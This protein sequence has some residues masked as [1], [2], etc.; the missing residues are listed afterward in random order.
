MSRT[1][2]HCSSS[3]IDEDP[4]RGDATCMGCGMVL[5]ESRI[6]SDVQFQ[7]TGSGAHE[8][9]GQFVSQDKAGTGGNGQPKTESR[10]VTYFKG[11]KLIQ[12]IASQLRINQHCINTAYNFFKLCVNSNYTR[13]RVRAHVVVA[14]LYM[15]CRL[16]NTSHLLLDFSDVTQVN[17]FDL[18]RTLNFLSRSLKINLP[19][20]DPC[21]YV[22]RFAIMLDFGDKQRDVVSLATRIVQR[23]KRDWMATGRRPTGI[24][25]AAH[26]F[27]RHELSMSIEQFRI[28]ETVVRKRLDEFANTAS[29]NL[30]IDEFNVVDLEDCADPPAYQE[31]RLRR[32]RDS[33]RQEE[34]MQADQVT[35]E[36]ENI[37]EAIESALRDKMKR[38]SYGATLIGQSRDISVPEL[39]EAQVQIQSEI[40][41]EIYSVAENGNAHNEQSPFQE[42]VNY[43]PT[44][45]SLG[46]ARQD[47]PASSSVLNSQPTTSQYQQES[48]IDD[49]DELKF[50]DLDEDELDAYILSEQE[51]KMKTDLWMVRNGQH[52]EEMEKKRQAKLEEEEKERANPKKKR[53]VIHKQ[54]INAAN[55]NEAMLQVIQEKHLS[56]KINYD[57]LKELDSDKPFSLRSPERSTKLPSPVKMQTIAQPIDQKPPRAVSPIKKPV[58][59]PVQ[60]P[61]EATTATEFIKPAS[62]V[63]QP[64][65]QEVTPTIQPKLA[66]TAKTKTQSR[67]KHR[68]MPMAMRAK[69]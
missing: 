2:P 49:G 19:T 39:Q 9:I 3:E 20:T 65:S 14:C 55:V 66:D 58:L 34:E 28:F 25:G 37:H 11:K 46:L 26:C 33:K 38:S 12:E 36:F 56:N 57:I 30:T 4:S 64:Q 18:G 1:C 5:E 54:P 52:M 48:L 31:A 43:G 68:A 29:G 15:T 50:D 16:E 63:K 27:W 22:L 42:Q 51:S 32:L 40:I 59:Q 6:V 21:L 53:R 10:E 69:K 61:M 23:M 7:E 17:V 60:Q 47:H 13:G 67:Y 41:D 8:V 44:L 35:Q 45:Q 24:C 62:P